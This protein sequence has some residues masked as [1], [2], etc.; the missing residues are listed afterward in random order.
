MAIS[1]GGGP[2]K[3][4]CCDSLRVLIA[5]HNQLSSLPASLGQLRALQVLQLRNNHL[6]SLPS[7]CVSG[8]SQLVYCCL[9]HNHLQKL[10]S[11]LSRL[12]RLAVLNVGS[13]HVVEPPRWLRALHSAVDLE[14]QSQVLGGHRCALKMLLL[15]LRELAVAMKDAKSAAAL[16]QA[17]GLRAV[18]AQWKRAAAAAGA[19]GPQ[20]KQHHGLLLPALGHSVEV[21]GFKLPLL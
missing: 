17:R 3:P 19:A 15:G 4:S 8:L 7:S 21:A 10:P 16:Q 20:G 13:N 1:I 5:D 2:S 12:P 11:C 6:R 18:K 14:D 9:Q